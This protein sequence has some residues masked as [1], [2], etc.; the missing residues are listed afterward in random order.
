MIIPVLMIGMSMT[1]VT[2]GDNDPDDEVMK[3]MMGQ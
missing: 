3:L 2:N 1:M